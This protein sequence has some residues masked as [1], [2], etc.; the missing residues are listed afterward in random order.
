MLGPSFAALMFLLPGGHLALTA[1]GAAAHT[2]RVVDVPEPSAREVEVELH[3]DAPEG[4][5][6]PDHI[7]R[8]INA[9]LGDAKRRAVTARARVT[10]PASAQKS[11]GI[12]LEI[13]SRDGEQRH[14]LEAQ[15]C[16]QLAD[17]T[18]LLIAVTVDPVAVARSLRELLTPSPKS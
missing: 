2:V 6:S 16:S 4:C 17:A 10:A 1:T 12:A 15:S 13:A 3:W 5:P 18:A 7:K 8:S 14:A 9:L 11:W